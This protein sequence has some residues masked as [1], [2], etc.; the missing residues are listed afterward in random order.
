MPRSNL[1]RVDETA[2]GAV[3]AGVLKSAGFTDDCMFI[4]AGDTVPNGVLD[5][6]SRF[7]ATEIVGFAGVFAAVAAAGFSIGVLLA[8]V[9]VS[10]NGIFPAAVGADASA[11]P[12]LVCDGGDDFCKFKAFSDGFDVKENDGDFCKPAP[13]PAPNENSGDAVILVPNILLDVSVLIPNEN[14]LAVVAAAVAVT[15][16][17]VS[18]EMPLLTLG[19][20]SVVDLSTLAAPNP[21]NDSCDF[22]ALPKNDFG[23]I[24]FIDDEDDE[25]G[26]GGGCVEA[27]LMVACLLSLAISFGLNNAADV[28]LD[29][30]GC[31]RIDSF[32]VG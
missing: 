6:T 29:T 13:A 12:S 30:C 10:N 31:G 9:G 23:V 7:F 5:V 21:P 20:V 14:E 22:S 16:A 26:G 2:A 3:G 15:G 32:C 17:K 4:F 24:E 27:D 11:L 19:A 28:V 25:D 18:N 1:N 8:A